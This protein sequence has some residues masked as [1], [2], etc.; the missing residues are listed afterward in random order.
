ME[1]KRDSSVHL[2]NMEIHIY[3]YLY[4]EPKKWRKVTKSQLEDLM[5]LFS[6]VDISYIGLK[7][8]THMYT[9]ICTG[10]HNQLLWVQFP[11][12]LACFLSLYDDCMWFDYHKEVHFYCDICRYYN[13]HVQMIINDY[14]YTPYWKAKYTCS[15][16]SS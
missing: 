1:A 7:L 4:I 13:Y 14:N 10:S 16:L 15:T 3:C 11:M 8:F 12:L 6:E 9:Y 2:L 5:S